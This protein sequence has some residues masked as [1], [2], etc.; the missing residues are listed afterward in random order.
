[1]ALTDTFIGENQLVKIVDHGNLKIKVCQLFEIL[2]TC[3]KQWILSSK[4]KIEK[5]L[6]TFGAG[7]VLY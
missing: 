5:N 1:M 6:P 3:L 2:F 7:R 4:H